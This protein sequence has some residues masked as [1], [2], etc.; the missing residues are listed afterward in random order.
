[1]IIAV[2]HV[3]G[4]LLG[5]LPFLG[6]NSSREP[7]NEK[8]NRYIKIASYYILFVNVSSVIFP[9]LVILIAYSV[10][11]YKIKNVKKISNYVASVIAIAN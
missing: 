4:F 11:I 3:C 2:C 8:C 7:E 1:V 9:S 5:I 6:W 10:I